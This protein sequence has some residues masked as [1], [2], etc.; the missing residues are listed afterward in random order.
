MP[1]QDQ[2]AAKQITVVTAGKSVVY[3]RG[4][5]LP[6]PA[7]DE[8]SNT[9]ALL[10]LGGA[11]RVVEVVYTPDELATRSQH[12]GGA[13]AASAAGMA[14]AVVGPPE[15]SDPRQPTAPVVLGPKPPDHGTKT[16]WVDYAASQGMP[17]DEAERM[18]RDALA[19]HYSDT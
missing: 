10:R 14:A 9:R 2:A 1:I 13:R 8:E 3:E 18:T 16:A 17:R 12:A 4:E 15:G 19:D 6:P 7:S 11:V 5:L